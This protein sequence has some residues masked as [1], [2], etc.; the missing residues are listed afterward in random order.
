MTD[1]YW[2]I[3][4]DIKS[5]WASVRT[6]L[7]RFAQENGRCWITVMV[8]VRG[9]EATAVMEPTATPIE[10][11]SLELPQSRLW[12]SVIRRMIS[13]APS[14]ETVVVVCT[15]Q[16]DGKGQPVCWSAP[17]VSRLFGVRQ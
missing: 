6:V 17:F 10:P 13:V 14:R 9:G 3:P 2:V 5:S 12:W 11:R 7:E 1:K 15:V 8:Q 4:E 16:V